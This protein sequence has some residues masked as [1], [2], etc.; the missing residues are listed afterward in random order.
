MRNQPAAICFFE[1]GHKVSNKSFKASWLRTALKFLIVFITLYGSLSFSP[2]KAQTIYLI[3]FAN[4]NDPSAVLRKGMAETRDNIEAEI[5]EVANVLGLQYKKAV[6]SGDDSN[7]AYLHNILENLDSS[8]DDIIFFF[9]IG[10]GIH[11]PEI[12][13]KWPQLSFA[14]SKHNRSME[15]ISF[16]E[17]IKGFEAKNPRLLIGIVEACNA[18]DGRI[19]YYEDEILGLASL[20][21]TQRDKERL[22]ELYLLSEGTV[23]SSSSEPGQKSYVS[24]Q[25]GY[26]SSAFIDAQ[27]DLTSV[28][29]YADWTTLL[30]KTKLRTQTLTRL[31][32]KNPKRQIPQYIVNVKGKQRDFR[33]KENFANKENIY[34]QQPNN[35]TFQHQVQQQQ[36]LVAKVVFFNENGRVYYVMPD[37]YVTEYNPYSGLQVVGYRIAPLQPQIFQYDLISY[38]NPYQFNRW[39]VDYQGRIMKWDQWVGWVMVG[40]VYY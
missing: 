28:S 19:E 27:K 26:F 12:D 30:E 7:L 24:S 14:K 13:S 34:T 35:F 15:L 20:G 29:D 31:K 3:V 9:Y 25:G 8:S 22:K 23:L 40:V 11:K 37:N 38:Y 18:L 4:T 10:H 5:T 39:G 36:F 17:I 16:S 2:A 21:Y 32:A 1:G 33:W 6:L